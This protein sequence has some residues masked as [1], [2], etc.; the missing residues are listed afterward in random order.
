LGFPVAGQKT[1]WLPARRP[2]PL[3]GPSGERSSHH[4]A[5]DRVRR[6]REAV[7]QGALVEPGAHWLHV[8]WRP[9]GGG[10]ER[11]I[12]RRFLVARHHPDSPNLA[13]AS[14]LPLPRRLPSTHGA[15][16]TPT[17]L[18]KMI[19]DVAKATIATMNTSAAAVTMRRVR[20]RPAATTSRS[21]G[22][23]SRA[24]SIRS[25]GTR[26][27][28]SRGR[29]PRRRAE[30]AGSPRARPGSCGRAG[31]RCVRSGRPSA[32]ASDRGRRSPRQPGSS[33]RLGLA[34]DA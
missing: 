3:V 34:G 24:S 10:K 32:T 31:P 16:P 14:S 15:V 8:R 27:S 21:D 11:T 7:L 6:R 2:G 12:G 25:A 23:R 22:P 19:C 30:L 5:A 29:R 1:A 33:H 4:T 28:P 13:S 26:R 17:S 9:A 18:M 20:S